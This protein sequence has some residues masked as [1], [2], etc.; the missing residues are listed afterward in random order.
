MQSLEECVIEFVADFTG[1]KP[2]RIQF[3][4]TLYGDLGVAG[5]DGVDLV[6]A[7]GKRF[8]V[9]LAG[10]ESVR[11][12][13]SEGLSIFAPLGLLWMILRLPF[14]KKRSPE[15]GSNLR[16]VRICDLVAFASAGRWMITAA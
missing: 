14:W 11:H 16:V 13:G 15:E 8:Q 7:Y 9:D 12:F 4:T 1:F 3:H 6:Q 2:E 5:D 10:F